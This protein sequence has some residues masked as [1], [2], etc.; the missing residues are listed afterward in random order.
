MTDVVYVSYANK[1]VLAT[2]SPN[3]FFDGLAAGKLMVVNFG[4]WL[5]D[6]TEQHGIGYYVNPEQPQILTDVLSPLVM[7]KDRLQQSQHN[8]RLIA[9]TFFSRGLAIQKLLKVVS[10]DRKEPTKEPEVYNLTA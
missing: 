6:I 8:A 5:K 4:G 9:E 7:D 10:P 3:K 2:G 1:P